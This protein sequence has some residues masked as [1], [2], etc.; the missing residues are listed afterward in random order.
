VTGCTGGSDEPVSSAPTPTPSEAVSTPKYWQDDSTRAEKKDDL[1]YG[2][3]VVF[4][5]S[6]AFEISRLA[7]VEKATADMQRKALRSAALDPAPDYDVEVQALSTAGTATVAISKDGLCATFTVP[8]SNR[9]SMSDLSYA[10][11]TATATAGEG[12]EAP[13]CT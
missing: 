4:A 7:G 2:G 13:T 12:N 1:L 3:V 8:N 11:A 5:Q 9:G 10:A 6:Y